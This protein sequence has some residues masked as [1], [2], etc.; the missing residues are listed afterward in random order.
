M[1]NSI[2]FGYRHESRGVAF[3][4]TLAEV[5][6]VFTGRWRAASERQAMDRIHRAGEE[7]YP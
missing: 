3:D 5:A 4:L 1:K 7:L 2:Q 6:I